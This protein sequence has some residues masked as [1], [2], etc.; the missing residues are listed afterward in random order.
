MYNK[1]NSEDLLKLKSISGEENVIYG[2]NIN[3]DYAHD[4]LGGIEVMPEVLIRAHSTEEIS[5]IM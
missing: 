4:E 1:I 2:E 5:E 3:P